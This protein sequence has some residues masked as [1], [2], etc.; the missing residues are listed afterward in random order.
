[1]SAYVP[2]TPLSAT[3]PRPRTSFASWFTPLI[4]LFCA[5]TFL[6]VV[7]I[8][9]PVLLRAETTPGT[10]VSSPQSHP[11]VAY[12][13]D[14]TTYTL[15]SQDNNPSA[16]IGDTVTIA[17][18]PDN[19]SQASTQTDRVLGLVFGGSGILLVVIAIALLARWWWIR[20]AVHAVVD[21]GQLV[22]ATIT[23]VRQY[24][25]H[26]GNRRLTKVSCE[27][28]DPSRITHTFRTV[29]RFE[30]RGYGME[31]LPVPVLPVYIDPDRPGK[32]YYVDDSVLDPRSASYA[33]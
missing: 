16:R 26:Q 31:D 9:G 8:S 18:N 17:F 27:W 6:P 32:R 20:Q 2:Y 23:G 7:W 25:A 4:L 29:G 22:E 13:V 3:T 30:R 11:V 14:G 10:I 12:V 28:V 33:G 5:L 1:M 24:A 21:S 15:R 19:P